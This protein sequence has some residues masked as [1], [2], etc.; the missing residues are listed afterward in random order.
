MQ[1]SLDSLG[2]YQV[3]LSE[4]SK[5]IG[6][7]CIVFEGRNVST[8]LNIPA[9]QQLHLSKEMCR[10]KVKAPFLAIGTEHL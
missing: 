9:E 7:R 1:G 8:S 2:C 4:E 6:T 3:V 10:S 5:C